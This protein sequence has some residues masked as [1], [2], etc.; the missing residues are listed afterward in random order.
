MRFIK[1]FIP[2][3]ITVLVPYITTT[4]QTLHSKDVFAKKKHRISIDAGLANYTNRDDLASPLLYKGYDKTIAFSY[5]YKG[6][7]NWHW[8]QIRIITGELKTSSLRNFADHYYGQLQYGYAHLMSGR[9]NTN[10]TFLVGGSWDNIASV[11]RYSFFPSLLRQSKGIAASTLNINLLCELS[12]LKKQRVIFLSS[13]PVLSYLERNGYVVGN[14]IH[15]LTSLNNYQRFQ[16]SS[17]YE[18]PLS[19]YFKLRLTYWFLYQRY[20]QPQKTISVFHGLS[21]GISFQF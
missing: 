8:V 3:I 17:L 11:R 21:G 14:T 13:A 20:S 7:K 4:A 16:F 19:A 2:F 9:T 5:T 15:Q 10:M 12:F 6:K 1:V 18:R